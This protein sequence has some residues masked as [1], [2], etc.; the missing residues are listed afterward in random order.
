MS[1]QQWAGVSLAVLVSIVVPGSFSIGNAA[2][3]SA[4][5]VNGLRNNALETHNTY[6]SAHKTPVLN[7]SQSLNA[8]A[9]KYADQLAVKGVFEH[10]G[11]PGIGEN[12]FVLH[13]TAPAINSSNLAKHAVKSWYDEASLYNYNSPDFSHQTG[14]FTQIVWKDSTQIGCGISQGASTIKGTRYN[15]FYVACHYNPPGNVMRQFASNVLK[16]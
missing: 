15:S 1:R 9:Q 14:H 16:P 7:V 11:M 8:S 5:D 12:L 2:G 4:L 6:R 10:S 3:S 13:T